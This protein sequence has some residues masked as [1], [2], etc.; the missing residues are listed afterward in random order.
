M[1]KTTGSRKSRRPRGRQM[2]PAQLKLQKQRRAFWAWQ[3]HFTK[4]VDMLMRRNGDPRTL[5]RQAEKL[6][7]ELVK[8]T[9]KRMPAVHNEY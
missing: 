7:D 9:M 8:I 6:A 2:T 3:E 5:A 1:T 4:A